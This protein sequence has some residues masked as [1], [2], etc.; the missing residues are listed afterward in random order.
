MKTAERAGW[1]ILLIPAASAEIANSGHTRGW[2]SIASTASPALQ[3]R[4]SVWVTRRSLRLSMAS[5]IDPPNIEPARRGPSWVRLTKPDVER[6]AC[7]AEDLERDTDDR[8]LV[9]QGG[10]EV[11]EPEPAELR[12]PAEGCDV[13]QQPRPRHYPT[14]DRLRPQPRLCTINLQRAPG[15]PSIASGG[16]GP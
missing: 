16:H 8:D 10:Y 5:A 13:D 3:V 4:A 11:S 15:R 1:S 12:V 6:R 7:Q 2:W 9:S 14:L